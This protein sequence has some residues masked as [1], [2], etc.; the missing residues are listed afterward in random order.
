MVFTLM[1]LIIL[2]KIQ[3][4]VTDKN[5]LESAMHLMKEVQVPATEKNEKTSSEFAQRRVFY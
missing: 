3:S 2:W 4:K 5:R 1:E